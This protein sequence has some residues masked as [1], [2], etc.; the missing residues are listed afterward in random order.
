MF[1]TKTRILCDR[2]GRC[3]F[4]Q[5]KKR[6]QVK[7]H[8]EPSLSI[9]LSLRQIRV[10]ELKFSLS[11][12]LGLALPCVSGEFQ[13]LKIEKYDDLV[14]IKLANGFSSIALY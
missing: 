11:N 7:V 1:L 12:Y 2:V 13:D 10:L 8:V 6:A 9:S 3:S 5:I 4:L 14:L